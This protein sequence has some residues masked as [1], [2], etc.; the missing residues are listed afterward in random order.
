MTNVLMPEPLFGGLTCAGRELVVEMD[1]LKMILPEGDVVIGGV[2]NTWML[3]GNWC[4]VKM[5][6]AHN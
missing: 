2:F 5:T 4:G 1:R 3:A 6:R